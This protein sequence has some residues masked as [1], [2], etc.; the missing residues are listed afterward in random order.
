MRRYLAKSAN[1][2]V[3]LILTRDADEPTQRSMIS[4]KYLVVKSCLLKSA[5]VKFSILLMGH[6]QLTPDEFASIPTEVDVG[7]LQRKD[8]K[9]MNP[10]THDFFLLCLQPFQGTYTLH[11]SASFHRHPGTALYLGF[12]VFIACFSARYPT[13]SKCLARRKKGRGCGSRNK[14]D[15]L[16][17]LQ[18]CNINCFVSPT[19]FCNAIYQF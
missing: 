13:M 17:V 19:S 18:F 10:L 15:C 16:I 4:P 8:T 5:E 3:I 9:S 12:S 2:I 6:W 7:Q 1:V 14:I 11:H